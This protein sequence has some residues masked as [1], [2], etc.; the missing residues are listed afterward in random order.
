ME[1]VEV[2]LWLEVMMAGPGSVE[3]QELQLA[4]RSSARLEFP[5][6]PATRAE[7]SWHAGVLA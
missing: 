1:V 2:L 7:V 3:G 4:C 6:R 5:V